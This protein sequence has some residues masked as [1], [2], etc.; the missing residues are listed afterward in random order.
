MIRPM[1]KQLIGVARFRRARLMQ[2]VALV[3]CLC[4]FSVGRAHAETLMLLDG[5]T[6]RGV[7]EG[8]D[9][10]LLKVKGGKDVELGR[11]WRIERSN[12][13]V[14]KA[15]DQT[16]ATIHLLGGGKIH[17]VKLATAEGEVRFDWL[18]GREAALPLNDV[19]AVR[20]KF[21]PA[22]DAALDPTPFIEASRA[23]RSRRDALFIEREGKLLSVEGV[24]EA[25]GPKK[26]TFRFNDESRTID[27][28]KVFGLT[29]ATTAEPPEAVGWAGVA[30]VDG[31]SVWGR[32][33][34]LADGTM[35]LDRTG[36][37]R[38]AV[39]WAK[40]HHVDFNSPRLAFVDELDP[41]R[42]VANAIVTY[43]WPMRRGRNVMN[44]TM[45]IGDQAY[46]RGLGV[47]AE[48]RLAYDLDGRFDRFIATIGVDASTAELGDCVFRVEGDGR[49]LLSQRMRGSDGAK[50]I[51]VDVGDV[52]RLEL[53]VEAGENLDIGDRANWANARLIR[54]AGE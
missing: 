27:R 24:L 14:G 54:A 18:G 20:F 30:L 6:V 53:V 38:L 7:V 12:R 45:K 40:V 39:P 33:V 8:L 49:E 28:D 42:E 34:A 16:V 23:E 35:Q 44:Q 41:V 5:T 31:S 1:A 50:T 10:G 19:R 51:R 21:K 17:A 32:P 13:P 48:S 15:P 29:L 46:D 37:A 4:L 26:L 25:I 2:T 11:V 22:G 52:E 3:A 9:D 47:H 43:A 36:E